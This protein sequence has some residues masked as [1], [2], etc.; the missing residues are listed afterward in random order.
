VT[1]WIQALW[2]R[3]NGSTLFD[4]LTAEQSVSMID[5]MLPIPSIEHDIEKVLA[6][7]CKNSARY[8]M[9]FFVRRIEIE[10]ESGVENYRA[11]PYRLHHLGK[12]VTHLTDE[13]LE[14]LRAA[15]D[16]D[17]YLFSYR[18]G[19]L[20]ASLFPHSSRE[21]G[22]S[23]RKLIV[24]RDIPTIEFVISILRAYNGD[25]F[26]PPICKSLVDALPEGHEL[27]GTV[28]IIF[29]S[30]GVVSGE[31]GLVTAY[32][33]KKALLEGWLNDDNPAVVNF[34]ARAIYSLEQRSAEEQ[35]RSEEELARRKLDF[36]PP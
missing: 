6:S 17:K 14:S 31:F 26:L 21:L 28:E 32:Q 8:V 1:A 25:S 23:L 33:N 2:F 19:R 11:V 4:D 9:E 35:R 15:Y 27:L 34:A 29:D 16:K 5:E 18:A 36:D 20:V 30:T 22:E 10:K 7:L 13:L 3:P 24:T 12:S